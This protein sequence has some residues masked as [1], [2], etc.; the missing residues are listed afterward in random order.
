MQ[1]PSFTPWRKACWD[2][3]PDTKLT[4]LLGAHSVSN[5]HFIPANYMRT[6]SSWAD[7]VPS[8]K[9]SQSY[10][11]FCNNAV[12]SLKATMNLAFYKYVLFVI[13]YP[14]I[15]LVRKQSQKMATL[16]GDLNTLSFEWWRFLHHY[17]IRGVVTIKAIKRDLQLAYIGTAPRPH[18]QLHSMGRVI[19]GKC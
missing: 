2:I 6:H 4:N 16:R 8:R 12:F 15:I 17:I 9:S 1:T 10:L 13:H 7:V 18:P 11:V 5:F 14:R 19:H 3:W